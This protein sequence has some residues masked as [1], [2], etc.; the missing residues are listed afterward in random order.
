[1]ITVD[2]AK[3]LGLDHE[4]GSL[5]AGKK[6]DIT[7]VDMRQPHLTPNWMVVHRL[8]HQA[9]ASDV[10]TVIVDGKILMEEG[11]VLTV[12]VEQAIDLG[13]REAQAMVD[14]AGLKAHMHDPGWGQI[15]RTFREPI[16][17]PRAGA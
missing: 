9:V 2:A 4:I 16:A 6:A 8:M 7:I 14:R 17:L 12:D 15:S 13:E 10:D 1:M 3:A 5:E 11:R